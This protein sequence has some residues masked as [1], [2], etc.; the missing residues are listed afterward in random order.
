MLKKCLVV[1]VICLL[2]Q[3]SIPMI[4]TSEDY[5][6]GEGHYTVFITIDG[7][8]LEIGNITGG[9][10]I[11]AKIIGRNISAET[12]Y[13]TIELNGGLILWPLF[14]V[15][16]G[17]SPCYIETEASTFVLGIGSV[18]ITVTADAMGEAN[19]TKTIS[20]FVFGPFIIIND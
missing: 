3:V 20:G 6:P 9:I 15:R 11:T 2:M 12:L 16:E 14:G 17:H 5:P 7:P 10:G 13:W 18:E 4:T 8:E 19:A 1:G